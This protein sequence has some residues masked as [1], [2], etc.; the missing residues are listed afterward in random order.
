M[1]CLFPIPTNA[2]ITD[3][4]RNAAI[5]TLTAMRCLYLH[6]RH[7]KEAMGLRLSFPLSSSAMLCRI[8]RRRPGAAFLRRRSAPPDR[9]GVA[10][11][12]R[13]AAVEAC[14]RIH[15]A[16][17]HDFAG[18]T[19]LMPFKVRRRRIHTSPSSSPPDRSGGDACL[20]P[21]G[22]TRRRSLT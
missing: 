9:P 3:A 2:L 21:S 20:R 17:T 14:R 4:T 16:S 18:S 15:T 19:L 1:S 13:L 12:V 8:A 22:S 11:D 5:R 6:L 10:S 7:H